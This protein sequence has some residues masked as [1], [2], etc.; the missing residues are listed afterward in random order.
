MSLIGGLRQRHTWAKPRGS[1]DS[2]DALARCEAA[3]RSLETRV[4]DVEQS[5]SDLEAGWAE[6]SARLPRPAASS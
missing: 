3:V 1:A 2:P 6:L 4:D 5:V